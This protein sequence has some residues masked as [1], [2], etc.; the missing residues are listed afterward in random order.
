MED[1]IMYTDKPLYVCNICS[2]VSAFFKVKYNWFALLVSGVLQSDYIYIYIH[3]YMLFH[4]GLL[5]DIKCSSLCYI[6]GPCCLS[7]L[8]SSVCL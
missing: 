1:Q 4:W 2:I 3:T 7:I 5:Q 6:V 8:Y